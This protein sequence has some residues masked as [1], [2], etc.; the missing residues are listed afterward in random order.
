MKSEVTKDMLCESLKGLLAQKPLD[1]ISI[2]AI[3]D[4][5]GLNRQTFYYHFDDIYQAV[6]WLLKK[7]A[8]SIFF[9]QRENLLVKEG[10]QL[11]FAYITENRAMCLNMLASVGN[12]YIYRFFYDELYAIIC[13]NLSYSEN[14]ASLNAVEHAQL[15]KYLV[16]SCGSYIVAWMMGIVEESPE[17]ITEFLVR[18]MDKHEQ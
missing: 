7:E 8:V 12:E 14:G 11:L 17:E 10:L 18:Q 1:K 9:D 2:K 13:N 16:I 15:A 3:T 6:D 5:C 4:G